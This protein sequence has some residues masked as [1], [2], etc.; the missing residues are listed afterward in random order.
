ML[1]AALATAAPV[2]A[3]NFALR[4]VTVH[5]ISAAEVPNAVLVVTGDR[6]AGFGARFP[7]P[8]GHKI[9]EAKGLHVYPG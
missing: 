7:I 3:E 5:P 8:K 6:I 4:G 1:A 2:H 9:V